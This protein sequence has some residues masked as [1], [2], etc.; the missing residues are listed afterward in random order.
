MNIFALILKNTCFD[1]CN[2]IRLI[3]LIIVRTVVFVIK[4]FFFPVCPFLCRSPR[5]A[6]NQP[7][8]KEGHGGTG[9]CGGVAGGTWSENTR[10]IRQKLCYVCQKVHDNPSDG[11]FKLLFNF[12]LVLFHIFLHCTRFN[13][14]CFCNAIFIMNLVETFKSFY[15]LSSIGCALHNWCY[16]NYLFRVI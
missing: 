16:F 1:L 2:L 14:T 7:G 3:E 4:Y 15:L 13:L 12:M 11:A 5:A 10:V 8:S 9:H 6:S